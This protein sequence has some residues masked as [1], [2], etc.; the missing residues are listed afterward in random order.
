MPEHKVCGKGEAKIRIQGLLSHPNSMAITLL[1]V[2]SRWNVMI[3]PSSCCVFHSMLED[4]SATLSKLQGKTCSD[5]RD[6]PPE[7]EWL[8]RRRARYVASRIAGP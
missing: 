6:F 1:N 2:L 4:L 8:A 7:R 3:R 5:M